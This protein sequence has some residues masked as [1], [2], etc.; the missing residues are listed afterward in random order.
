MKR[1]YSFFVVLAIALVTIGCSKTEHLDYNIGD[2]VLKATVEADV[3]TKVGF[4]NSTNWPFFWHTGD[5]IWVNGG[6]METSSPTGSAS[7]N[8]T[9][10]GIDT[11]TGYAVYPFSKATRNVSNN[12]VTWNFP[13]SYSLSTLDADFFATAQDVPMY[14]VVNNGSAHFKHLAAICAF[15]FTNWEYTGEHTFT[16][17]TTKKITGDFTVDLTASVPELKTTADGTDKVTVTF[18]RQAGSANSFVVYVPVPTGT[19]NLYLEVKVGNSIKF[20][21]EAI[22]VIVERGDIVNSTFGSSTLVGGNVASNQSELAQALGNGGNVSLTSNVTVDSPLSVEKDVTLDLGGKTLSLGTPSVSGGAPAVKSASAVSGPVITLKGGSLTIQNGTIENNIAGCDGISIIGSNATDEIGLTI[23][24]D[25]T[26]KAVDCAVVVPGA[27]ASENI[28]IN[29]AGTLVSTGAGYAALQANGNTKGLKV[30]VTGGKIYNQQDK[31][32]GIYFPCTTNLNISGGLISG[33]TGIYQKSGEL[34]ISGG[35][36][37]GV[38][39]KVAYTYNGSGCNETGDALVIENCNYP[40]GA[41]AVSITGGTFEST[42]ANCIGSYAGN[43][44]TV[45]VT[46]FVK[47]GTFSDP[48]ACYHLGENAD[49]IVNLAKN[50]TGAGFKTVSGQKVALNL[51]SD[52]VYTVEKPLVGSSGTETLGF[53]FNQ[54]STVQITGGKITSYEAKMLINNYTNLTLSGVELAPSA[55]PDMTHPNNGN[56]QAYYVLSN[57]CGEINIINGTV[58]TAPETDVDGQ[59]VYAMDV[60]KYSTYP[61]V[62][63]N[64][65]DGVTIN[66]DIE[67]TGEGASQKLNITGGTINGKFVVADSYKEHAKAGIAISGGTIYDGSAFAY[68]SGNANVKLGESVIVDVTANEVLPIGGN[69][70]SSVTIDG[71]SKKITF[72]QLNSDWNHILTSNNAKLVINNASIT[73]SGHNDGPWNRHDLNFACDVELNNVTS[74]KA[75]ALKAGATLSNVTIND[76]NTSDTYAIWIQPKGQTISISGCTIDMIACTDGRG[77]KIDNQYLGDEE[78]KVTLNVSKT[79]FKTEEKSAILVKT[80]KGADIILSE[81]DITKVAADSTNPVWVDSDATASFDLVT[82]SGGT[83][84]QEQ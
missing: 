46:G 66:G 29:T 30:N 4:T 79:V 64:I 82:V 61:Q 35:T 65:K 13:T 62:T 28:T 17:E 81:L 74:D 39:A 80:T 34:T 76:A 57:N 27:N 71:N 38:G 63:V 21:K 83:K 11:Q 7:A 60:C 54:G 55:I 68:F 70:V 67:Y 6:V 58:I 84:V 23:G 47:G 3:N 78:A 49:V 33:A 72:N 41:P 16:L 8:F 50:Y 73:N 69:N 45:P 48:S 59:V 32:A 19:Y 40:G 14:A 18:N 31:S 5:Q 42:N 75:I 9:G 12:V 77:I 36:I 51:G 15:K 37:K 26:I 56:L 53:Q 24:S 43:E 2:S 1:F 10:T 52:V 44:E 25:V 22:G 20:T